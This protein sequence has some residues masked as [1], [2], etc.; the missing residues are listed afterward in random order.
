MADYNVTEHFKY[1][2]F[3]CH[4]GTEYPF[5]W[6]DRLLKLC[7]QLEKI[8]VKCG[9]PITITSGYRTP[10]YNHHIGGAPKS[11]HV[12]GKAADIIVKGMDAHSAHDLILK[13]YKDGELE[14]GG[15]GKYDSWCHV[16]IRE[17]NGHLAQWN[18]SHEP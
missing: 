2:E 18:G 14:I 11:Q 1:S 5:A 17:N 6:T 8:R 9:L 7:Q 3:S 12:Q 13:M 15:L 16:D 4:D 10:D